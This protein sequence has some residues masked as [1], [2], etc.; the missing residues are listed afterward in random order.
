MGD[1]PRVTARASGS[2]PVALAASLALVLVACLATVVAARDEPLSRIALQARQRQAA[3]GGGAST[4]AIQPGSVG[5]T[6]IHLQATY[7]V[8]LD[9][10]YGRRAFRAVSVMVV[11]NTSGGPID[12]LELNTVAARLGRL[13]FRST[14]VDGRAVT[15]RISDQTVLLS[16]GGVL[17][18]GGTA[19]VRLVFS[20]TFRS[21][22]S[23]HDWLF[24]RANGIVNA[25]RWLPWISRA[26]PFDR[27]NVGDPFVTPVSPRVRVAITTDRRLRIAT[28]GRRTAVSGLTQTF[29]AEN[30]RDFN[31]TASPYYRVLSDTV[32]DTRVVV[33]YRQAATARTLM[34]WARAALSRM[35]RLVGRYPYPV[36]RV[37]ESAGGYGMESPGLVWIPSGVAASRLPYLVSHEVAHQWFYATV[38][39]DQASEPYADEAL[40]DFLARYTLRSRRASRCPASRL[41]LSIYR[42]SRSC[43]FE[44]VYIQGGNFL[45]DL[46]RR[47]GSSAFWA[48]IRDYYASYRFRLAGTKDLLVVLDSHTALD[49]VPRYGPRFPGYY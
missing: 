28:G 14:T 33:Y 34:R 30:V 25:Y 7:D 48:G 37:G 6:S 10:R 29:V 3:A 41:D 16:L 2:R 1:N 20:A 26:R 31:F 27:A 45:D 11:R 38:G 19:T 5:R 43:Y 9:L 47:M 40:A 12:R 46:R 23:G 21:T 17:P 44:I 22:T 13:R 36:F 8:R 39:N 49:L 32:G 4:G 42:Y 35:E 24:T 15:P 18:P